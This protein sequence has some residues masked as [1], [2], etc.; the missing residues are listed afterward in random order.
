MLAL[1][2]RYR[3][4][5]I[6]VVVQQVL[7]VSM[8]LAGLG[9]VGMAID[10][11]RHAVDAGAAAPRWPWG[12]DMP[13]AWPPLG[14]V[15]GI[16]L[17]IVLVAFVQ[18]SLR[19]HTAIV[20]ARLSQ[21]IVVQLRSDVYDK[22]Q[23]LSFRFFDANASGS[24][25]NRVTGD[26][27]A[28]RMF[29]DGVIIEVLTVVLSLAV[30]LTYMLSIHP[31]LTLA[32]LATTPL[33][34]VAA[35]T[36]SRLVKP[37][38]LHNRT[39]SDRMILTLSENV[40]GVLVVKGFGRQQAEIEK[41]RAANRAVQDHKRTIF[42]KISLFQPGMGLLTQINLGVLLSYGGY[43][44]VHGQLRLGEGLFVFAGLLSEFANQ[45]GQIT[46]ITNS[47]QASLTGAQR[48]FDVLDTP[49][50]VTS[51]KSPTLL[52]RGRGRVRFDAV[53]FGYGAN[54]G[55][56]EQIDFTAQPG[57]C[58]AIVGATG[59]GKS[60]LLSLVPR[61]YDVSAGRV[62][63]DGVDVRQMDLDDLRRRIGLVFQENF[64][65]SNTIAA[66][67]AFGNPQAS[68]QDIESAARIAAAHDFIQSLPEGYRTIVGEYGANLSGGQRQRLALARAILL[69]PA[70]LIL[71]DPTSAIDPQTEHGILAAMEAAM[72]GRTTFVVAHRLST[73]RRA[74][75]ILVLEA[76]RIVQVGTH[77]ELLA[78]PGHY[79]QAAQLQL[80]AG[81]ESVAAHVPSTL[82][83]SVKRP[84]REAA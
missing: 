7:L 29:V 41:F 73:L 38:Y 68:Q 72:R 17:A 22:L 4:D 6:R 27:Q 44:V 55:I 8:G 46:N 48:V 54:A 71:D 69:N 3:F 19:Y 35:V 2:W 31:G 42:Q 24:I 50:E 59:A 25:I 14:V 18:S 16:A 61:F 36:F 81:E 20:I 82:R 30:Y 58:I 15:V 67:I 75:R 78:Q 12:A 70:I 23:R 34:W 43:L 79:R 33:L 83:P 10:V 66:N 26:V 1:A 76:G 60:T 13:A 84:V 45:V 53:S 9:L 77:E 11:I 51:P 57:E 65:F 52:Q 74:D 80:A 21:R 5:C 47:V 63:I 49:L 28:M 37:A 40:Q 56:L 64:L 32:S 39:L 62:S